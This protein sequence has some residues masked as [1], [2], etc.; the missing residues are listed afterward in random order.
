M[1]NNTLII[2]RLVSAPEINETENGK[3]ESIITLAVPRPYRN[4]DGE[5]DTDFIP[6][7]LFGG[8]A[9]NTALYCKS[10]DL[11]G[12]KGRLSRTSED[13]PLKIIAEKVTFLSSRKENEE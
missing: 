3:K 6:C 7:V 8:I 13:E 4:Y 11:V 2:G 12:I 1:L 5:F 10:G 9:E